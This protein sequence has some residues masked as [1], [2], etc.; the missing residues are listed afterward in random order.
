MLI[1]QLAWI[2]QILFHFSTSMT[3]LSILM[4][5]RRLVAGTYSRTYK[6]AIWVAMAFSILITFIF[7]A[8]L[9]T[10]CT[11]LASYWLQYDYKHPLA[12]YHCIPVDTRSAL[13]KTSGVLSV[14]TDFYSLMLPAILLTRIQITKRQRIGLMVIFGVGYT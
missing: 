5:Y 1:S 8:I 14:V 4:F 10:A 12:H 7:L 2:V 3:K 6:W 11:P 9:F 13:G